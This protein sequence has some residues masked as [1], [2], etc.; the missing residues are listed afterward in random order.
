[1]VRRSL[2]LFLLCLF[3]AYYAAADE[4]I[5]D[6]YFHSLAIPASSQEDY[7]QL[8]QLL[9]YKTLEQA[10][11]LCEQIVEDNTRL[12]ETNPILYGKLLANLGMILNF[13][14]YYEN[15]LE[16]LDNAI[17]HLEPNLPQFSP[18]LMNVI[19]AKSSTLMSLGKL[20]EAKQELRRAQHI[21]HRDDGVYSATQLPIVEELFKLSYRRGKYLD[22]DKQQ[23]FT[24]KVSERAYGYDSE[25]LLPT[26]IRLGKYFSDRAALSSHFGDNEMRY[27]RESL[28]RKS[29]ELYERAIK[30]IEVT[31]GPNDPRLVKPLQGLSQTRLMQR[32][33]NKSEQALERAL[34]VIESNP[35]TD[36]P[37]RID[38]IIR[39]GDLYT[40]TSD[41]RAGDLYLRAWSLMHENADYNWLKVQAFGSPTRLYPRAQSVVYLDRQPSSAAENSELFL[42][43]E[44]TVKAN[45]RVGNVK[46]LGKNVPNDQV[47][48]LRSQLAITRFRPRIVDGKI[49]ETQ[50]LIIHQRF[51]VAGRTEKE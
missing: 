28:F 22:A 26:L 33:N 2:A 44:Y 48:R 50:N 12:Q 14:E 19:M 27:P 46:L 6:Y 36:L 31:Y 11:V 34:Y 21:T 35:T 30:I 5:F 7:R 13:G 40:L 17:A 45:G 8:S 38:A 47:R 18:Q 3:A 49:V 23:T 24:L 9:G 20:D 16:L 4:D 25:E 15:S 39:L 29:L 32:T 51:V 42:D 10:I 1:M 43:A 37:D 41:S